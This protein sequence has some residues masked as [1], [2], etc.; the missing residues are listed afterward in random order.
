[1][2]WHVALIIGETR[3]TTVNIC[4]KKRRVPKMEMCLDSASI[5]TQKI[6][7][8]AFS[9]HTALHVFHFIHAACFWLLRLRNFR[10]LTTGDRLPSECSNLQHPSISHHTANKNTRK[11]DELVN[12]L[13]R[14][15]ISFEFHECVDV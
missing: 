5:K 3:D 8:W 2:I 9:K 14:L 11:Y 7:T 6:P 4:S 1:M 12:I 13:I 15:H 10:Y